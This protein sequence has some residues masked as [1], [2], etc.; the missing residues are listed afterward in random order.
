MTVIMEVKMN[1][2][3]T[4]YDV[5]IY[6]RLSRDDGKQGE[7]ISIENQ[8]KFLTE[9]V[10]ERSWNL[11]KV[12]VDDGFSGT[13]FER[14][15]F[16]K[17]IKDVEHGVINCIITKDLSR[18][19]RNYSKVGYYT[20]E[21]FVDKGV[22]YI[23]VNDNV[24]TKD[25]DNDIAPFKNILNEMYA[26]DISRKIRS[27]RSLNA[28]QGKFMGSYTPYGYMKS[29]EDKHKLIVDP[30][31]V[32][33]MRSIVSQYI[34]GE[35]ARNIANE[36]NKKGVLSPRAYF[37]KKRN[38]IN[39]LQESNTWCS[40][41]IIQLLKNPVYLGDMVQGKRKVV[42]FKTKKRYIVPKDDWIV[43]KDTHEAII[44]REEEK[45]INQFIGN[46]RK[47][48][49]TKQGEV[50]LFSGILRCADCGGNM[51]FCLKKA[52]GNEYPIYRCSKYNNHG[53]IVCSNHT[54]SATIL[55]KFV[56]E[57]IQYHANI[58]R[59]NKGKVIDKYIELKQEKTNRDY[60][61]IKKQNTDITARLRQLEN[62]CV[63]LFEERTNGNVPDGVFK[64]LMLKY[65]EEQNQLNVS[66][67]DVEYSLNSINNEVAD[68]ATWIK[69]FEKQCNITKLTRKLLLY[70][71]ENITIFEKNN[72]NLKI[73]R[74]VIKYK[75][76]NNL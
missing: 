67:K 50:S 9:F 66:L 58:L 19:G 30:E 59:I 36:L 18:L 44:N 20:D 23:A 28:R 7:S 47:C 65:S 75:F 60:I 34:S 37:Y 53:S 51:S 17:M 41:T 32:D 16:K 21:Y 31:V 49:S 26:K 76:F 46:K 64:K 2:Q 74:I 73:P 45:I 11:K 40:N 43:V 57:N 6:C 55:E 62:L 10:E 8:K 3:S 72:N 61:A 13:T 68:T 38:R 48:R 69:E 39:P 42:S 29:P 24:D 22:R 15:S 12:Y 1:L 63:N 14:P 52:N 35:T 56:L 25:D 4:I 71:I 70:L 33:V 27:S 54:I 5:G